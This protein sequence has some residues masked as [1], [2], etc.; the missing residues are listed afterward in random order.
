MLRDVPGLPAFDG[1]LM[2]QVVASRH[3]SIGLCLPERERCA[4]P[5][6]GGKA[7]S[8]DRSNSRGW[9]RGAFIPPELGVGAMQEMIFARVARRA[10]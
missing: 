6:G 8:W 2:K 4:H 3:L 1:Q 5:G 9:F 7:Q 10:V